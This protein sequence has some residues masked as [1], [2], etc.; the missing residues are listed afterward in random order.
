MSR[1]KRISASQRRMFVFLKNCEER[2][3]NFSL[4]RLASAAGVQADTIGTYISKG[5]FT[6]FLIPAGNDKYSVQGVTKLTESE[7]HQHITQ[8]QSIREL[9]YSCR[10]PLSRALL[11]KSK[12]NMILALELYNR[13][14][15]ENRL[16]GFVV[17]FCIAWEQLLKAEINEKYSDDKIFRPAKTGRYRETISLKDCLNLLYQKKDLV[18]KNLEQIKF[19]RD[20]ATHLLMPEIQGL[21]SLVF[22]AGVLNYAE[23]F[24][25][26][27]KVPFLPHS[28]VGLLTLI[29][30]Q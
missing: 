10:Y 21:L 14:S 30:E 23:A 1:T 22:Q 11:R 8:T 27:A 5:Y 13:P 16:D 12:D 9:G 18:C 2:G 26:V 7:F 24:K 15:L 17:L 3:T 6:N 29:V 20:E 25:R 28:S 19:L 4:G